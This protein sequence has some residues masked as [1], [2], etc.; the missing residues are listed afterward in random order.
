[1]SPVLGSRRI[2][3]SAVLLG[4]YT[5]PPRPGAT[6]PSAVVYLGGVGHSW[7]FSVRV[8]N[9]PILSPVYSANQKRSCA[10]I[11]LRRGDELGVGT[12]QNFATCVTASMPMISEPRKS[13]AHGLPLE[14]TMVRSTYIPCGPGGRF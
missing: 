14:S 7:N 3:R 9:M 4:A 1:I 12:G 11:R 8:S 13:G 5:Y 2:R 10:S 6:T